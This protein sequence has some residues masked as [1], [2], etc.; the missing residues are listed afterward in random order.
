MT[1]LIAFGTLVI[2]LKEYPKQ[3]SKNEVRRSAMEHENN[4]HSSS[5][6]G[7]NISDRLEDIDAPLPSDDELE[8]V[9]ELPPTSLTLVNEYEIDGPILERADKLWKEYQV[10]NNRKSTEEGK[11]FPSDKI[12]MVSASE[13]LKKKQ[14]G[15]MRLK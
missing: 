13:K 4:I 11:L 8:K 6:N 5:N 1:I 9:E 7:M 3:Q 15:L 2:G 12:Q 14:L 10:I